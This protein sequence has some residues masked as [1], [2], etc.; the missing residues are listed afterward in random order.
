L[1]YAA[2]AVAVQSILRPILGPT[3]LI[4][5]LFIWFGLGVGL[6]AV[7]TLIRHALIRRRT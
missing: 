6:A 1:V 2:I 4:T 3:D 7:Y 5:G